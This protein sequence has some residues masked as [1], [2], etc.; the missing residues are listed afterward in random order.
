VRFEDNPIPPYDGVP[1]VVVDAYLTRVY[2]DLIGREPLPGEMEQDRATLRAGDLGLDARLDLIDRLMGGDD[3]YREVHDR[4]VFDDLSGRFLDG[5]GQETLIAEMEFQRFL[6]QQDSLAGG[7]AYP[8]FNLLAD[9]LERVI[10]SVDAHRA[11][12]IDW[13]EVNRRFCDNSIYD[14]IN[15]NSFNFVNATF[16]DLYGRYPT[17]AEFEQ[18]YA[19]VEYGSPSV[20]FGEVV[21]DKDSYL[22]VLVADPEFDEGAIRWWA[23]KLLVRP[24]TGAEMVAW[25]EVAGPDVDVRELQRILISSDEYADF[26]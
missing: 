9:R 17:E 22:Q 10:L 11:G 14:E 2:I 23:E 18:A 26:E 8:F 3:A 12:T 5:T 21:Q 4:K 6:A 15:M 16:D 20:L 7:I 1:T 19:A 13:R 25:R 24:I